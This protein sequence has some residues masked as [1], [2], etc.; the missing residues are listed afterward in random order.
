MKKFLSTLAMAATLSTGAAFAGDYPDQAITLVV[1]YGPGGASDLAGRALSEAARPYLGQPLTVVNKPGAGG[2]NG[3]RSVAEG[4][5]DGY[6]VLLARVGMA[7]TPAVNPQ[8]SVDWDAYTFLGALEASPMILAVKGDSPYTSVEEL[9]TAIK[10]SNGS[11]SY[12]A[13]GA[14]A[15]DG[16]ST[17]A[18]LSDVDL[19][20]LTAATLVPYKGGGE[21]ATALLGGHVDFLA[22]SAGSLIPHIKSGDMKALMVFAPERM[23]ELPEVP[24]A[25]ELGYKQAGQVTGWSALYGPK[26]L[27]ADVV[28]KWDE[29]LAKVATDETWLTLTERRG[30][31]STVGKVDMPAYAKEQYELFHGLAKK[32]GYLPAE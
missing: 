4:E 14:T 13:S 10:D 26:D 29:V 22:I 30:S 19:D 24:T 17:Q 8:G 25:A 20:P 2:M 9:L 21:L 16:F 28:A 15:I 6:T 1:P 31:I 27:P 23:T 3:A 5:A 11:M 18:L 32:F 12:A 7:L